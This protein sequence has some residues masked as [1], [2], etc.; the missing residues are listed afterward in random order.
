MRKKQIKKPVPMLLQQI[1]LE[2]QKNNLKETAK[3]KH[4]EKENKKN[5]LENKKN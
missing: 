2:Q 1:G 3:L 4:L 5:S